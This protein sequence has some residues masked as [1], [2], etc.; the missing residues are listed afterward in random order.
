MNRIE[1][2]AYRGGARGQPC[3]L[4]ISGAGCDGGGE[5]TVFAHIR[6]SHTGRGIKASDISGADACFFCHAVFDGIAYREHEGRLT[7]EEWSFYA[8]R[9]LQETMERRVEQGLLTVKG[10]K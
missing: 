7:K 9:G 8:L 6:D 3:T 4:R 10:A 5:T 1:S 2:K